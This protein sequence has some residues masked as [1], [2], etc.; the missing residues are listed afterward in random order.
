MDTNEEEMCIDK[1]QIDDDCD[2]NH[3][4][5]AEIMENIRRK[6]LGK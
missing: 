5:Q 4:S 2:E 3:I 6:N 1:I